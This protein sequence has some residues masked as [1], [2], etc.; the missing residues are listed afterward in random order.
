M[1]DMMKAKLDAVLAD[2]L[3]KQA[4]ELTEVLLREDD[5][6]ADTDFAFLGQPWAFCAS[7]VEFNG[8][9]IPIRAEKVC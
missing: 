5:V 2:T 7:Q 6:R 3:R 9:H 4:E 1:D 8:S